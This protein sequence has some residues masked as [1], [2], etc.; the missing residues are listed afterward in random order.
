MGHRDHRDGTEDTEK[1]VFCF[2]FKDPAHRFLANEDCE[3]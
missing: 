3:D 2:H 1:K